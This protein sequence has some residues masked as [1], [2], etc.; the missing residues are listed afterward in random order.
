MEKPFLTDIKVIRDRARKHIE[1]GAVTPGYQ[2]DPGKVVRILNEALATEIVCA[3]RYKRH[4]FMAKGIHSEPVAQE[5]LEHAREEEAHADRIAAR[6]TQLNGAPDFSPQGL[7]TRS[8]SEYVEGE[9]LLEMIKEDLVAERIAIESYSEMVRFF[10]DKDPTSRRLMEE[11]L[12]KEEEHAEDLA[13]LLQTLEP[14]QM[15]RVERASNF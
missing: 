5:F 12:A 2:G 10:G 11:V 4:Y 15:E 13:T 14:A 6:I 9:S 1:Q 3:L 7:L 8:H